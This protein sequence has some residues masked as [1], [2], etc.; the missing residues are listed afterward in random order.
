MG[1]WCG[2]P[3]RNRGKQCLLPEPAVTTPTALHSVPAWA[4]SD[5]GSSPRPRGPLSIAQHFHPS[6]RRSRALASMCLITHTKRW[7]GSVYMNTSDTGDPG[8]AAGL[9]GP[10]GATL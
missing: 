10:T 9:Q 6:T 2:Y 8:P 4:Q 7:R 5:S 1:A 3:P